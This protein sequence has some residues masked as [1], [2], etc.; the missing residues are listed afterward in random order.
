VYKY[1]VQQAGI[2]P[3]YT[4]AVQDP[5]IVICPT[6]FPHAT[7]YVITSESAGRSDVSFE[8]QLSKKRFSG[9]LP[10]GR[11]AM[12]LVGEKGDLLASYD[13]K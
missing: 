11:A 9:S 7:L 6:R 12:L 4:I 2:S 10:S 1:A 5:G 3:T 8:D 13:W